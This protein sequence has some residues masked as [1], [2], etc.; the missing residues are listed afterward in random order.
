[1]A[2]LVVSSEVEQWTRHSKKNLYK[3]FSSSSNK[4]TLPSSFYETSITL[5]PKPDK[6][7]TGKE[8]YRPLY[9]MSID[10]KI[11][12]KRLTMELNNG[13]KGSSS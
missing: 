3:S 2:S 7:T 12:N 1:M 8:N 13:L 6:D 5:M 9:L 11:L 10:A 4:R